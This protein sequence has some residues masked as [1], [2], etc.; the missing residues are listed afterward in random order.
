MVGC[1]DDTGSF[2]AGADSSGSVDPGT[3]VCQDSEDAEGQTECAR[4]TEIC[5][6]TFEVYIADSDFPIYQE[7]QLRMPSMAR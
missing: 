2:D 1:G 7:E 5:R 3:F 4:K 6:V